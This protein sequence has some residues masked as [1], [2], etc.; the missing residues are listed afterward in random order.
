MR[1]CPQRLTAETCLARPQHRRLPL[2]GHRDRPDCPSPY[3]L[4]IAPQG[5]RVR[6]LHQN[7]APPL[8]PRALRKGARVQPCERRRPDRFCG[9]GAREQSFRRANNGRQPQRGHVRAAELPEPHLAGVRARVL[10]GFFHPSA[11]DHTESHLVSHADTACLESSSM[12]RAA[13]PS[14]APLATRVRSWRNWRTDSTGSIEW[15]DLKRCSCRPHPTDDSLTASTTVTSTRSVWSPFTKP[16]KGFQNS[17]T[18]GTQRDER[19]EGGGV[20]GAASKGQ[21]RVH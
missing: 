11:A 10:R 16:S 19:G 14:Q 20:C 12:P 9:V 7:T 1:C 18:C 2:H 6:L 15:V 13:R 17:R 21:K 8:H 3:R 5:A 4:F